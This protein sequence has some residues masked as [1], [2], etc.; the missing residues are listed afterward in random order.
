MFKVS[1]KTEYGLRAMIYLARQ[2]K[3][4]VR[5]IKDISRKEGISFDFLEKIISQ[6]QSAGILKSKKGIQGGYCLA[7][8]S[9]SIT[10]AEIAQALEGKISPVS[11]SL[12]RKS[13]KCL[14]KNVWDKVKEA[15]FK[16]LDSITLSDLVK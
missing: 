5:S 10:V 12:C 7:K 14:S 13:K 11:C 4:E 3:N 15:L 2:K 16:T 6:L 8:P 1:K 9:K